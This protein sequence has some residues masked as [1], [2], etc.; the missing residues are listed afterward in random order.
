[1]GYFSKSGEGCKLDDQC[2]QCCLGDEACPIF[3]AQT[4]F[5]YDAT[6]NKIATKVLNTIVSNEKGCEMFV[7][8]NK[9]IKHNIDTH[10]GCDNIVDEMK[11]PLL[12]KLMEKYDY[13]ELQDILNK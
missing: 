8:F 13:K 4:T 6:K 5:N 3:S 2:A 12:K 11:I 1:M 7:M 10:I 9:K